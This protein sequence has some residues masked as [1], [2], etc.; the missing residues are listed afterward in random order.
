MPR[1]KRALFT[2]GQPVTLCKWGLEGSET[3]VISS[4]TAVYVALTNGNT[5]TNYR[6]MVTMDNQ[7]GPFG[8][9]QRFLF[10]NEIRAR[11]IKPAVKAA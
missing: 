10:E 2:V 1:S 6:Y 4:R 7:R 11:V 3:G 8:A 5:Y 9:S